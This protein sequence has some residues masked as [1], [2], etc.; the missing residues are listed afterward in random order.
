MTR[1]S[2]CLAQHYDGM[3]LEELN[4][5]TQA[6]ENR[7]QPWWAKLL[8]KIGLSALGLRN[9][10]E[11]SNEYPAPMFRALPYSGRIGDRNLGRHAEQGARPTL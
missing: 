3:V 8:D 10:R 2:R 1:D 9:Q 5:P 4:M 6:N 11:R 7:P